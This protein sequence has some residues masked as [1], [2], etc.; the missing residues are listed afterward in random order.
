MHQVEFHRNQIFYRLPQSLCQTL[1][2][3]GEIK[4]VPQ[5]VG[6]GPLLPR[7]EENFS[8]ATFW[9]SNFVLK[10]RNLKF[11]FHRH[12]RLKLSEMG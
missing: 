10:S 4:S 12:L 3:A 11:A 1:F 7:S 6:C 8:R 5:L 9:A 2:D